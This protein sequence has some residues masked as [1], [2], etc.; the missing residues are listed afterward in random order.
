MRPCMRWLIPL[1]VVG[2]AVPAL[3]QSGAPEPV[4]TLEEA[5]AIALD[6]NHR[7]RAADAGIDAAQA[8][9]DE[10]GAGRLPNVDLVETFSYTTNPVFVF[11]TLLG[12]EEFSEANFDPAYLNEPDA[13]SNWNT[14]AEVSL[15][16]YV[17][18]R[19]R[20]G[21]DAAQAGLQAATAGRERTRQEVV[22]DV[23]DAHTATALAESYLGAVRESLNVVRENLRL[24]TDLREAGLVVESDRL[25]ALVRESE[26]LE[27][28]AFAEAE[29]ATARAALNFAMGRPLDTPVAVAGGEPEP[30]AAGS[31]DELTAD[32]AGA[33]PDVLAADAQSRATEAA[34]RAAR[35]ERL[36]EVGVA[37]RVEANAE[38]YP[39]ADGTNWSVFGVARWRVFGAGA[40]ARLRRAEAQAEQARRMR[41]LAVEG[42]GLEVRRAWYRMEAAGK[43][44]ERSRLDVERAVA[45]LAIVRDRYSEGLANLVELLDAENALTR[46]RTREV[47]TLRDYRM[48]DA[49]LRLAAGR[50]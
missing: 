18:G 4:L 32:L 23:V 3:A 5:V 6:N 19:I 26:V 7:L 22:R 25:Q 45:S 38:D 9:V 17:G 36:P 11:G 48:A 30:L 21:R 16:V 24:V 42:A 39:G 40:A 34:V 8:S 41:E 13:L 33:R 49:A 35:G 2:A 15:P 1:A 10:A 44:R 20:H 27:M 28:E 37:G 31:L 50:L 29:A 14:L 43:S 46:A 12:Q 47:E